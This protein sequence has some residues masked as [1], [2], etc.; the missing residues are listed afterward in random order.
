MLTSRQFL[1]NTDPVIA[2]SMTWI[3]LQLQH[4][5]T[6]AQSKRF[7]CALSSMVGCAGATSVAPVLV[8]GKANLKQPATILISLKHV[9]GSRTQHEHTIMALV[10]P[11]PVD[12]VITPVDRALSVILMLQV[13]AEHSDYFQIQGET[14]QQL[15]SIVEDELRKSMAANDGYQR[16]WITVHLDVE[17]GDLS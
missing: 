16:D 1:S 13:A 15:L 2:K 11:Y 14:A 4:E 7:F 12:E 3:S 8:P 17:E 10:H 9:G 6:G 5:R